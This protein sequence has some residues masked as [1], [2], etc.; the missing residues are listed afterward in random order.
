MLTIH[1]PS[2]AQCKAKFVKKLAIA[3]SGAHTLQPSQPK[4]C[5][6]KDRL[7]NL[8]WIVILVLAV[9]GWLLARRPAA[10]DAAAAKALA[11]TRQSLRSQGFRTDLA[12]FDFSTPP[13]VR[14]RAAVLTNTVHYRFDGSIPEHPNLLPPVGNDSAMVVWKLDALKRQD[15]SSD[16]D[17][18]PLSWDE[19]RNAVNQNQ[20]LYDPACAAILSGPIR[21]NL[22]AS[23]GSSMLLPHLAVMKNLTQTF[24]D[25]T[26]LALH[27]GNPSAAWTNLLAATRLV[28]AYDPEPAD[29]SHLVHIACAVLAYNTLWQALQTNGW[30]DDQL[31]RLQQEWESVDYFTNLTTTVAFQC[32][33]YVQACEFEGRRSD[34][35]DYTFSEFCKMAFIYPLGLWAELKDNWKHQAYRQHGSFEDQ[36]ALLLFY[37]DR[38]VEL[39]NAVRATTWAQ[40]RQFPGV[41]NEMV[42]QS[43]YQSR[44]QAS[45]NLRRIGMGL[46]GRGVSLLSRTAEAEALRR[47]L[48]T[49]LALERYRLRHGTYPSSLAGLSPAFLKTPLPDFMDGQPLRYRLAADGHFLLYSIGVDGVDN[50]G[51]L[52]WWW[53]EAGM[54][55]PMRPGAAQ[56]EF[57]L[58]W[59]LPA[60]A[61]AIQE[62]HQREERAEQSRNYREEQLE[63][64]ADWNQSPGRQARAAQILA[65]NWAPAL[66]AGFFGGRPAAEF[67]RNGNATSNHLS[68]AELMTPR[69]VITGDEPET[70]TYEFPINYNAITNHG[71]FLLLDA[72]TDPDSMFA[73]DSGAKVQERSRA[74]NGDCLLVWHTIFDPPGQHALQVELTWN[75]AGGAETWCR[76]P[77]IA[78]TT[79]NLCQFSF[80]SSV[81][82][83]DQGARFHARLPEPNGNFSIECVTT[84]GAHL[85]T[86]T[87]STTNGEFNL[88]WNLVDDHGQKLHGETF[89]S[90]VHLTLPDSGRTQ[91][92]KGP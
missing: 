71:F 78:V 67:L 84:N 40:M 31:A 81:Y 50:G 6:M 86:L 76:G 36:Q 68:L 82:D 15:R 65:T 56:P 51:K 77:A 60:S 49:A 83:V 48:I 17:S 88:L 9:A 14:A 63:S 25:R 34:R 30:T 27:D 57:D 69:Q 47:V 42:F 24:G 41:T 85:T 1:K 13:D 10:P 2:V 92:L 32:A 62:L 87:G 7:G 38:E 52:R 46:P 12:D 43:K 73:P 35:D 58:V 29:V 61:G 91:T 21:F 70:L 53:R 89:N 19:F 20:S 5:P 55:R 18:D 11:E 74:V 79:S 3:S 22:D 8:C 45:M 90:I 33:S 44:A 64:A 26:V 59:P 23:R 16:D 39:R 66:D 54:E 4:D 28:T 37:R 72:D 80:D 75:N